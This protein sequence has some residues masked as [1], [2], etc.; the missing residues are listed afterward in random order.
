MYICSANKKQ[1]VMNTS[2]FLLHQVYFKNG[3]YSQVCSNSFNVS[4]L[5]ELLSYYR[6]FL[7]NGYVYEFQFNRFSKSLGDMFVVIYSL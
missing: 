5:R 6:V 3:T 4:S 1:I 7:R 2:K